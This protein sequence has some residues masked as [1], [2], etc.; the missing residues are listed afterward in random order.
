M[1]D[2]IAESLKRV[3]SRAFFGVLGIAIFA[4]GIW[5]LLYLITL[6]APHLK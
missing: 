1:F 4:F 2:D 3:F 5:G 6:I